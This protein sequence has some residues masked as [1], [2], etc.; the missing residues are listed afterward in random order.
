MSLAGK[1]LFITG[2]TRGIG[3]AIAMRAARDGARI[4]I[5]AKTSDPNPKLPGTIYTA[6]KEIEGAGGQC[7][8]CVVDVREEAQV[9]AAVD[10][11]ARLFG[12]IDVVVNNASAIALVGTLELPMK[13]YDLMQTVNA[14][15]TY[16]VSKL[17]LPHLLKAANPHILNIAPPLNLAPHWFKNHV[18]YT[19]AKYGMSM[20]VLGMAEEFRDDGV[21]VNALWPRTAIATAAMS[22]LGGADIGRQCRREEIMADAAHAVLTRPA[23]DATGNF[24]IDEDLLRETGVSDFEQYAVEPGHPLLPDF[25]LDV[26]PEALVK[27][28]EAHGGEAAYKSAGGDAG[29]AAAAAEAGNPEVE[30]IFTK[31]SGL[32]S[33]DLVKSTGATYLFDLK[34]DGKY[35]LDLK[36][37]EGAYGRGDAPAKTD[38]TM[39]MSSENFVKMFSGQLKPA[40]AF[41]SGKLK[42]KGDMGK[43]MKLEKLMGKMQSKL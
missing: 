40:V 19:M 21:A 4:V 41:M 16:L 12:G 30:A 9:Q 10:E 42:I 13:R 38:T 32:L 1:T 15:G 11:A 29:G 28:M 17:C 6:A 34:E 43:A 25:F 23:R 36:A 3:K 18:G 7:L 5:A 37:G 39:T 33:A 2:A 35:H 31:I 27:H 22:M 20:C 24:Y 14:R 26:D 8:P